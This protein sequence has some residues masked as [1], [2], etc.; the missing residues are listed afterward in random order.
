MIVIQLSFDNHAIRAVIQLFQSNLLRTRISIT[1]IFQLQAILGVEG[2]KLY[3]IYY[4]NVIRACNIFWGFA[5]L[6][7]NNYPIDIL[8]R[9]NLSIYFLYRDKIGYRAIL[10]YFVLLQYLDDCIEDLSQFSAI[11]QNKLKFEGYLFTGFVVVS[12]PTLMSTCEIHF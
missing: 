7:D 4:I 3:I 12:A 2:C 5:A 6:L 10:F 8:T 11:F 1:F 9:L